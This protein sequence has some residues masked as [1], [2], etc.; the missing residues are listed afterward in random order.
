MTCNEKNIRFEVYNMKDNM[1]MGQQIERRKQTLTEADAELLRDAFKQA[2]KDAAPD[3]AEATTAVIQEQLERAI[4]RGVVGWL[5]RL[6]IAMMLL[7]AGYGYIKTGGK[8]P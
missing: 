5:K 4:G 3:I 2:I 8:L 1:A 6:M 7:A